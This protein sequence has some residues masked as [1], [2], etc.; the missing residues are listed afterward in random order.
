MTLIADEQ[1]PASIKVEVKGLNFFYGGAKPSLK[2]INL[3][4]GTKIGRAH[5]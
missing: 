3:A 4:L 2:N 1:K 5:V